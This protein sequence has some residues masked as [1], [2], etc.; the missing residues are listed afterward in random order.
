MRAID[1]EVASQPE[2]W[3]RAIELAPAA[4]LPASGLRLAVA[5][6]GTSLYVA[7]AY[8]AAREAEGAG[9][10]D[11]WAASEFP[12][13]RTYDALLAITRSGT[14]T[15]V[16]DLLRA[17]RGAEDTF[18]VTGVPDSPVTGLAGTTVALAFADERSVVQTRFATT[19]LV[20]LLAHAG[21]D[22]EP[23]VAAAE[24]ILAE[25]LPIDPGR[26]RRFQFL[27]RGW[28]VGLASEAALKL[29]EAARAWA[30][31]YPAMEYRHGPIALADAETAVMSFGPLDPT[32]AA[33]ITATGATLL[34]PNPEAPLAALV[35]AHRMAIALA[36][37][38]DL[39]P[40]APRNLT[41]SVV[42]S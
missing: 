5:G 9:E 35:L 34:E 36:R 40:D 12:Q 8:A 6:C 20:L 27:G 21:I 41:R 17:S 42:L 22:L 13:A 18:A 26:F 23:S 19:T 11:A 25:P 7:Q 39:D 29:R 16:L 28:S 4:H 15:E 24:R 14:T 38:G 32:L 30:E 1:Q 10:T 37:S 2:M 3:R 31:A 33:Q